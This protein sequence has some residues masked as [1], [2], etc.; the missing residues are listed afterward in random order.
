MNIVLN[1][2]QKTVE[3]IIYMIKGMPSQPSFL[4]DLETQLTEQTAEVPEGT[5]ELPVVAP[6]KKK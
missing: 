2:D 5:E 1:L 6:K 3:D 4:A